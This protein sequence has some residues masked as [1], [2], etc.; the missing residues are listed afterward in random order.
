MSL[1]SLIVSVPVVKPSDQASKARAVMRDE[2]SRS[3]AV[4][5]HNNLVGILT[6]SDVLKISS[7]K[8][9]ITA[10]GLLWRPLVSVDVSD[11]PI[12]A[13]KILIRNKVKQLPVFDNGEY[14][15][16]IRDVDLL[17]KILSQD[18]KSKKKRVSEVMKKRVK[19]FLLDDSVEKSS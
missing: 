2:K 13:G 9:N 18:Y 6:R 4:M 15:G 8:S 16:V 12:V 19:T 11:E 17:K 7:S 1:K 10:N 5:R 3:I 14:L